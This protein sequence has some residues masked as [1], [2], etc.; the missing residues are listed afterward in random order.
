MDERAR[1]C[2]RRWGYNRLPHLVPI[3]WLEKFRRQ[4]LKWQQACYDAT[5]FPTQELIDVA[6]T[7]ANAMLRAYDKLEA[8]AEEAGHTSL[9]AYQWEFEL[10][11]GTPVI[12]VRER[13]EL[14]RVDAGGRQCQVWA[15]E[16][17]ADIIEKFPILVKAKDCFPGA[18]IIPMKTDKLV[19]GALDDALTDLPF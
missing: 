13:A 19:I 18:E 17:V 1:G 15:L 4:K 2:N 5:P 7:Q 16:E 14:C 11:D 10:S 6:R 12:L 9:P 3:E 8:L